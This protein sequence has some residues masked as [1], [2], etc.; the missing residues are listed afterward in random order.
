M[1]RKSV[2]LEV[3][4]AEMRYLRETEGLTNKQIAER[5]DCAPATVY[6]YIGKRSNAVANA[7]AQNKPCPV[8]ERIATGRYDEE[9]VVEVESTMETEKKPAVSEPSFSSFAPSLTVVKRREIIDFKG[10]YCLFTV[11][12]GEGTVDMKGGVME[13]TLD[14][15]A[16]FHFIRELMEIHK[17]FK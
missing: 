14:K 10:D 11:D 6:R 17:L 8:P 12:T 13:G 1:N 15:E 2:R 7:Q 3:T 4:P 9:P 16:L 5:L